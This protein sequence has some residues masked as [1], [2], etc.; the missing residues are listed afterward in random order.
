[1]LEKKCRE[2]DI[3][4]QLIDPELTYHENLVNLERLTHQKL[5]KQKVKHERNRK[6]ESI[7]DIG[8]SL[9][10]M[11]FPSDTEYEASKMERLAGKRYEEEI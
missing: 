3:D 11:G 1:M 9:R 4:V 6:K 8:E 5:T 2:R 7:K 10:E